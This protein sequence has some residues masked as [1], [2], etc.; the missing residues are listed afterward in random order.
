VPHDTISQL[1]NHF[2]TTF[3]VQNDFAGL[4][5]DLDTIKSQFQS[6]PSFY[7]A[8]IAV[9]AMDLGYPHATSIV[10]RGTARL[11]A[12]KAYRVSIAEFQKEIGRTRSTESNACLW[13]T[14]FLG[15][16]EVRSS[17][18]APGAI[19]LTVNQLMFDNTGDGWVKHILYGTLKILQV[20]G[21]DAHLTGP[22]RSFFLTVRLFEICRSC[23]YHEPTFLGQADWV[24]LME[25][26]WEG[27]LAKEWH[28]KE[29]LLDLMISCSSLGHRW[30][31]SGSFMYSKY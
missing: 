9:G 22:G 25:R 6:T 10:P 1:T 5:L 3:L 29:S 26:M 31:I 11:E 13:T 12:L 18:S 17:S 28:P 20:R 15:L 30:A 21:P 24:S 27:D 4:S 2:F 16:F 8:A 14:F 23:F 19:W 7:H